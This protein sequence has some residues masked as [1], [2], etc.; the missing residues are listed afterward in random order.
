[1]SV[2][3]RQK[4]GNGVIFRTKRAIAHN[5]IPP[6]LKKQGFYGR[7]HLGNFGDLR[8]NGLTREKWPLGFLE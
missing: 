1:M 2:S 7:V 8:H 3:R 6:Y 5:F 4:A